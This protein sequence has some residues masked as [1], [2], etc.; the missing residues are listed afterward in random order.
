MPDHVRFRCPF[1][2]QGEQENTILNVP[3]KGNRAERLLAMRES[4]RA[5][6]ADRKRIAVRFIL[7]STVLEG[8][9][10]LAQLSERMLPYQIEFLAADIDSRLYP[11]MPYHPFWKRFRARFRSGTRYR[12]YATLALMTALY[13]GQFG[14]PR[15]LHDFCNKLQDLVQDAIARGDADPIFVFGSLRKSG[16]KFWLFR[17]ER[18]AFG[19]YVDQ[20]KIA[21]P[22]VN[23]ANF[24]IVKAPLYPPEFGRYSPDCEIVVTRDVDVARLPDTVKMRIR[25]DANMVHRSNGVRINDLFDQQPTGLWIPK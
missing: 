14:I 18:G 13:T 19:I 9:E 15:G 6:R 4:L 25:R 11:Y 2:V 8:C 10:S 17:M 23:D 24:S 21:D 5:F 7:P 16:E 12:R 3:L 20:D 1:E 22:A